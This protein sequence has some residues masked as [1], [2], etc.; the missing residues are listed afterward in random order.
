MPWPIG[1]DIFV[2]VPAPNWNFSD[3]EP[4]PYSIRIF[5]FLPLAKQE[6]V[7]IT[8]SRYNGDFNGKG[9]QKNSDGSIDTH[10]LGYG[11]DLQCSG[12]LICQCTLWNQSETMRTSKQP[13][14]TSKRA[15]CFNVMGKTQVVLDVPHVR[16]P[17]RTNQ[18]QWRLQRNPYG[19]SWRLLGCPHGLWLVP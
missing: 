5:F 18:R 19:R 13:S 7:L 6:N 10:F 12:I 16:V 11:W 1:W 4:V 14:G 17:Y 15:T 2:K 3:Y 8:F 9:D